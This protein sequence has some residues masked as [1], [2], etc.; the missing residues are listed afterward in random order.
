VLLSALILTAALSDA[1]Q[2]GNSAPPPDLAQLR[3]GMTAA[4]VRA[5]L[6]PPKRVGRQVVHKRCLEQWV[7][8]TPFAVRIDFDWVQGRPSQILTVHSISPPRR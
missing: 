6:G 1:L 5:L 8:E 7:Y 4:E 3:Q 2:G